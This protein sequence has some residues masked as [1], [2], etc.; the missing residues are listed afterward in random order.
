MRPSRVKVRPYRA[1]RLPYLGRDAFRR[2]MEAGLVYDKGKR[3][4][5]VDLLTDL[6]R[7]NAILRDDLGWELTAEM[8]CGI[9]G[10]EVYCNVC[11]FK[12]S[13]PGV[14]YTCFCPDCVDERG[15]FQEY[16]RAQKASLTL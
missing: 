16:I 7:V 6:D 11:E 3:F 2:L 9:C 5:F 14:G 4:F 15:S 10:G 12:D 1:F 8:R 13:C